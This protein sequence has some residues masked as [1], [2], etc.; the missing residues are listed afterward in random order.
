MAAQPNII[1]VFVQSDELFGALVEMLIDDGLF[2]RLTVHCHNIRLLY[3]AAS[4]CITFAAIW[5]RWH[6]GAIWHDPIAAKWYCP[7][8]LM[9]YENLEFFSDYQNDRRRRGLPYGCM[10]LWMIDPQNDVHEDAVE[11]EPEGL[12]SPDYVVGR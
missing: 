5:R 6:V 4:T 7:Q 1:T 8:I 2:A 10:P 11:S 12:F 3:R 9:R